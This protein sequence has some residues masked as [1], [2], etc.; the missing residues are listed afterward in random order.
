MK[1]LLLVLA[2]I[3]TG[4]FV[5]CSDPYKD[6]YLT[7]YDGSQD[8]FLWISLMHRRTYVSGDTEFE[9]LNLGRHKVPTLIYPRRTK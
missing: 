9:Y 4:F 3:T 8:A 6:C 1:K 7:T 2:I 5:S